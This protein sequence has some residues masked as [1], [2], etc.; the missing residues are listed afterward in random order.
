MTQQKDSTPEQ[1]IRVF[2]RMNKG[3]DKVDPGDIV[4]FFSDSFKPLTCDF[5]PDTA[6]N[7]ILGRF[8]FISV[9]SS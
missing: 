3:F 4:K 8:Y 1:F 9:R 5:L 2:N 7:S 6:K